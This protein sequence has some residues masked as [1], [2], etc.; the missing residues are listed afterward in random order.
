MQ[1]GVIARQHAGRVGRGLPSAARVVGQAVQQAAE[2]QAGHLLHIT[3]G[4]SMHGK[5]K[6][7]CMGEGEEDGGVCRSPLVEDLV[8]E[9]RIA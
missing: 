6:C 9:G 8:L 7:G 5:N 3:D 4:R 1:V 2:Y